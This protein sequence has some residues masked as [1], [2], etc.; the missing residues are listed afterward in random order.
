VDEFTGKPEHEAE[1]PSQA[2][3]G[4]ECRSLAS[5]ETVASQITPVT[6]AMPRVIRALRH[7]DF[8]LFWVGNFLSNV[9]TWM[10][11]VAQGWLVLQ[12][13]PSNS[14]FWLGMVGFA[15]TS[16]MLLFSLLGG[17]IADRVDRRKLMMWTQSAMMLVAFV[18]W[19]LTA[20]N[21]ITVP[22]IIL[23]AFAT[24]SAMSLNL[25]AYQ[26]LVPQLVPRQ[27]LANAI[28]L[29]SAQFNL[30]RVLGPTLGGIAM[31]YL[32]ISGNFLLNALSF[33]AVLVALLQITYPPVYPVSEERTWW[34]DMADGFRYVFE[35]RE[36]TLL[37]VLAA[38]IAALG[39]PYLTFVP[40][41][42]KQILHTNA[43][44]YGLL[45]AGNGCGAFLGA[46]VLAYKKTMRNR[47]HF[48]ARA[49]LTFYMFIMLF[50]FSRNFYLSGFF[51]SAA[52]F[53]IVLMIASVN[54]LLQHLSDDHM[55]G[56]VMSLYALASLGLTPVGCLL[57]GTLAGS[58]SAPVTLAMLSAIAFVLTAVVYA[59][60]KELRAL[61]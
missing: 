47:G 8:R 45:M 6:T 53:C 46:L 54:T 11:N 19:G 39:I 9:G 31:A 32:G 13:A 7:R 38:L 20:A 22:L 48:V 17:A 36:M 10:Q 34:G 51:L 15:S 49:A 5:Q 28:A 55:R 14:A 42:A 2:D 16:P 59:T 18:L 24:G 56:R 43:R 29:N 27:D 41:F 44:G 21:K 37:L 35:R 1:A 12:L 3:E 52:G 33:L 61:D 30:S 26:S 40:L 25:P 23:L 58:L 50:S 60:Q 57:A 4:P